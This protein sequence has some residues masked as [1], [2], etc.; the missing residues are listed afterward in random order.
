MEQTS[1]AQMSEMTV[2]DQEWRACIEPLLPLGSQMVSQMADPEDP[3]LRQEVYRFLLGGV[4]LAHVGLF[5]GDPEHPDFWPILN[6]AFNWGLPNADDVYK[7]A[8]LAADGVYKLSGS[9]GTVRLIDF[10]IGGGDFYPRGGKPGPTFANYDVDSL[11]IDEDGSLEVI[12]SKERPPGHDGDWWQLDPEA[13]YILM[14]QR[15]YD[16]VN[17][18]DGRFAIERLDS[19]AVKP[20]MSAQEI[21]TNLRQISTW[22]ETWAQYT[23]ALIGLDRSHGLIN[24]VSV[25]SYGEGGLLGTRQMYIHGIF[26][27]GP[28]EALIYET[29][30]PEECRYWSVTLYDLNGSAIDYMNRQTSLNGH[31]ARV[32]EDGRFRAV[33]SASDPGVP[34]WLDTAG[35]SIGEIFGR[36]Q[37]SSS[38]PVPEVKKVPVADVRQYLPS[39]TPVVSAQARDE[40][41]RQRNKA[42]QLRR[43]W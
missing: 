5:L 21:A 36:W 13:T 10:Q 41:V 6:M 32:D 3:Q 18:I 43:R 27:L 14:R 4:A 34:N 40:S 19:P 16:W 25:D 17:E 7:L 1:V 39:D 9:R 24:K 22:V 8:P 42:A 2:A 38:N 37:D 11:Q 23:N 30:L 20:R 12:L 35:Y 31:T 15:S 33:I 29:E 28:D 26:E